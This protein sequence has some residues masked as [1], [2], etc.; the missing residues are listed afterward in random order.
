MRVV[1]RQ[2][3]WVEIVCGPMFSG[4]SEELIRRLTRAT[5]AG[6]R[7]ELVRPSS[8]TRG[9]DELVSHAGRRMRAR[10]LGHLDELR[11]VEADVLGVD[12]VQFFPFEIVEIIDELAGSGMRVVC[13]GL[14]MDYRRRPWPVTQS[15][16]ARAEFADKLQAV[17]HRCGGPAT[18]SQRLD[19]DGSPASESGPAIEIGAGGR[20]EARCR[21]CYLPGR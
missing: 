3:G 20:Y 16:M 6:Q 2:G 4:K 15:L 17:C 13:S 21:G 5:I 9:P 14:D 12:E 8:D 11:R 19:E 1:P 7:V 18:L 10:R